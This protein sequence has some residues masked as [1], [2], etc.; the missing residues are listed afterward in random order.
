MQWRMI[1]PARF[2]RGCRETGGAVENS[3]CAS[4]KSV[5]ALSDSRR[6]SA[7]PV[8]LASVA[9]RVAARGISAGQLFHHGGDRMTPPSASFHARLEFERRARIA[10]ASPRGGSLRLKPP[11]SSAACSTAPHRPRKRRDRWNLYPAHQAS[12]R[13]RCT[14]R[15]SMK[16]NHQAEQVFPLAQPS[17]SSLPRADGRQEC[18]AERLR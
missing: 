3:E 13:G 2:R 17:D 10:V 18:A 16:P 14:A 7:D 9:P 6:G 8:E 12:C 11:N 4:P 1:P 5:H 15:R